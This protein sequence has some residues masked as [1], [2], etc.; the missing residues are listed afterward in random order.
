ML[1]LV[2]LVDALD[3]W[4]LTSAWSP[5]C[6]FVASVALIWFYPSSDKWTPTR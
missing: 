6:V 2:P 5:L 4:L 3:P 1:P